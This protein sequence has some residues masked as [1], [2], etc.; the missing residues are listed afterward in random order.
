MEK[1]GRADGFFWG[2]EMP[3]PERGGNFADL[4]LVDADFVETGDHIADYNDGV[5]YT[6]PVGS[7]AGR[8]VGKHMMYDLGGNVLEWVGS[9]YSSFGEYDVARGACWKGFVDNHLKASV[10]RPVRKPS[11]S[12]GNGDTSGLY[13]FRVVLAKVPVIAEKENENETAPEGAPEK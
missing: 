2:A 12:P 1:H 13:G 8:P 3:P 7:Y 5:A 4:S 6:S 10:R 11:L 9:D